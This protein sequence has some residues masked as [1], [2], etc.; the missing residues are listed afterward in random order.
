MSRLLRRRMCSGSPPSLISS[1]DRTGFSVGV[2]TLASIGHASWSR[3]RGAMPA[4][5]VDMLSPVAPLCATL[6]GSA[7]AT[8]APPPSGPS[9]RRA[10]RRSRMNVFAKSVATA[11]GA[12]GA[13]AGLAARRW[14]R[15][16]R[17]QKREGG[18]LQTRRRGTHG[19]ALSAR[20]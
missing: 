3:S 15:R 19:R 18:S 6:A 14:R 16:W 11:G 2:P 4:P 9:R 7:S 10:R 12:P 13:G 8:A 5:A 20:S 17:N 1:N